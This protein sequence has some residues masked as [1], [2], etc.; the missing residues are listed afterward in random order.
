MIDILLAFGNI[1]GGM[2]LIAFF[3]SI[4]GK[5]EVSFLHKL[6]FYMQYV[7]ILAIT[8]LLEGTF[9]VFIYSYYHLPFFDVLF[10][11][12]TIFLFIIIVI[13]YHS[14]FNLNTDFLLLKK[15]GVSSKISIFQPSS[16]PFFLG[17]LC[18]SVVCLLASFFHY[19]F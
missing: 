10:I 6:T 5:I 18:L 1:F 4:W 9:I 8:L 15:L 17:T 7:F 14:V 13:P 3:A 2:I 12:S 11:A 16:S 19:F